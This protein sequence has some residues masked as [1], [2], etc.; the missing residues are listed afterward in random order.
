MSVLSV[1]VGAMAALRLLRRAA[2]AVRGRAAAG[3]RGAASGGRPPAV[4]QRIEEKRRAALLG[5]GTARIEAQHKRVSS[6]AVP[7]QGGTG[8]RHS[9]AGQDR[10]AGP[11]RPRP[12][13]GRLWFVAGAVPQGS[14]A[15]AAPQSGG[16]CCSP[17][18]KENFRRLR[19][20]GARGRAGQAAA[21]VWSEGPEGRARSWSNGN[22]AGERAGGRDDDC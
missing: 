19:S 10:G 16:T 1:L 6:G 4:P 20:A 5:G 2:G 11:Q 21:R 13:A 9:T 8:G 14:L 17:G 18:Q 3:S 12:A 15:G 22:R 7:P